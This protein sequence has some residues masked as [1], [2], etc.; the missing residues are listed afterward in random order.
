MRV[1]GNIRDVSWKECLN[2]LKQTADEETVKEYANSMKRLPRAL[3][4]LTKDLKI[5]VKT[6]KALQHT[7]MDEYKAKLFDEVPAYQ[8]LRYCSKVLTQKGAF[9]QFKDSILA[10]KAE[11]VRDFKTWDFLIESFLEDCACDTDEGMDAEY[12]LFDEKNKNSV[13]L[14]WRE[15]GM[16]FN[17]RA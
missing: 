2:L 3:S 13:G 7:N 11:R 4:E 16:K 1:C 10:D 9:R 8:M 12:L 6:H 14:D 17:R 5:R 15:F